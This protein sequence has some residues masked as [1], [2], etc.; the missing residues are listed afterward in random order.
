M[1]IP[2]LASLKLIKVKTNEIM[3]VIVITE[4][5]A[6]TI[7]ITAESE[8]G[9]WAFEANP[10]NLEKEVIIYSKELAV[11]DDLALILE[12]LCTSS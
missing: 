5:I 3:L 7:L 4:N 1:L 9:L 2:F 8:R 12:M 10:E 6:N 11:R